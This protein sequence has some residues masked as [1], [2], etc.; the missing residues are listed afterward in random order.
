MNLK[1]IC[2]SYLLQQF[3]NKRDMFY[4]VFTLNLYVSL[5]NIKYYF[6]ILHFFEFDVLTIKSKNLSH[7]K[8][9]SKDKLYV[10][11]SVLGIRA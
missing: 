6:Q 11:V 10:P 8:S 3:Q 2:L 5:I 9:K 4:L 7:V 1:I